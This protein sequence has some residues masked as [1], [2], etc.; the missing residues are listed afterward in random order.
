MILAFAL[1]AY[2]L[3]THPKKLDFEHLAEE[4]KERIPKRL[5]ELQ[6]KHNKYYKEKDPEKKSKI[7]TVEEIIVSREPF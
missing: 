5:R 7:M 6:E 1:A 3:Y 2:Y 4:S